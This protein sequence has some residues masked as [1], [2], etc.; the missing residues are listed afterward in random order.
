[1]VKIFLFVIIKVMMHFFHI[2]FH[3]GCN[4]GRARPGQHGP[5]STGRAGIAHIYRVE[6]GPTPTS[7]YAVLG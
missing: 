6:T 4:V 3:L 1:M 2:A 7:G 5:H